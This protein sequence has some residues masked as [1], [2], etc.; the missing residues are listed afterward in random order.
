MSLIFVNMLF[1]PGDSESARPRIGLLLEQAMR[2]RRIGIGLF[3]ATDGLLPE[4]SSGSDCAGISGKTLFAAL[5]S[6]ELFADEPDGPQ[7]TPRE[8]LGPRACWIGMTGLKP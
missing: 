3:S 2:D 1:V 7:G 4:S 8:L 6:H 5:M